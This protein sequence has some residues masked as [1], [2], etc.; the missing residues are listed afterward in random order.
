MQR[1]RRRHSATLLARQTPADAGAYYGK[2]IAAI[3]D[4]LFDADD[5]ATI[6]AL[7]QLMALAEEAQSDGKVLSAARHAAAR[8]PASRRH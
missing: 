6:D 1:Y 7:E 4:A 5:A 3:D 2:L 8:S